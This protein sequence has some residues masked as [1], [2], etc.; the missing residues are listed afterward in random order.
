[1]EC[2]CDE[3]PGRVDAS[4]SIAVVLLMLYEVEETRERIDADPGNRLEAT[5]SPHEAAV[6]NA[7]QIYKEK[8]VGTTNG[9]TTAGT[10]AG[11][12]T[13]PSQTTGRSCQRYLL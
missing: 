9:S 8:E 12:A 3:E 5:G 13:R 11:D 4:S 2:E 10:G 7:S 6:M 1:V